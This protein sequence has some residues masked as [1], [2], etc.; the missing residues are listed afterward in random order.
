MVFVWESHA[1]LINSCISKQFFFRY[2][3]LN[4]SL[5]YSATYRLTQVIAEFDGF[6]VIYVKKLK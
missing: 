3:V 1:K 4:F 2:K 6:E 5:M